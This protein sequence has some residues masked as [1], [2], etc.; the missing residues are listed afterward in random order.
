MPFN[1]CCGWTQT[2]TLLPLVQRGPLTARTP[3]ASA[4]P[5][6]RRLG[7]DAHLSFSS[8]SLFFQLSLKSLSPLDKLKLLQFCALI[9]INAGDAKKNRLA[10]GKQNNLTSGLGFFPFIAL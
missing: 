7:P 1:T 8:P 4:G 10:L 5:A 6:G 2:P 9:E 3:S